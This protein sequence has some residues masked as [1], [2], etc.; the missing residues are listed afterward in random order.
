MLALVFV[1]HS[2]FDVG[3]SMFDV[4]SFHSILGKNNL[5]LMILAPRLCPMPFILR[6]WDD[7]EDG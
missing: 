1:F 4:H 6:L 2:A 5:A 7:G 3:R